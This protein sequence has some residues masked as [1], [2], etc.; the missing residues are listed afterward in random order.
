MNKIRD[1]ETVLETDRS[2]RFF[3]KESEWFL[4]TREG[5]ELG[6][7]KSK[8]D[9]E[10]ALNDYIAFVSSADAKTLETFYKTLLV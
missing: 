3:Q 8:K 7:F 10:Q 9:A 1:G 2:T 4:N 6:P 5:F